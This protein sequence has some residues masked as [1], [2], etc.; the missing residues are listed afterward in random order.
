MSFLDFR[1][2]PVTKA[3]FED[4]LATASFVKVVIKNLDCY[5][6]ACSGYATFCNLNSMHFMATPI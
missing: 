2:Q 4:I 5:R 1:A 3:L 6:A